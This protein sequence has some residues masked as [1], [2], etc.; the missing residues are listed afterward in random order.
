VPRRR[1]RVKCVGHLVTVEEAVD[2]GACDGRTLY[3]NGVGT[4]D[5][6]RLYNADLLEISRD[7]QLG[8]EETL[9]FSPTGAGRT[10]A[11]QQNI[12]QGITFGVPG[13]LDTRSRAESGLCLQVRAPTEAS[14]SRTRVLRPTT[15]TTSS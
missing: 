12:L 8:A 10:L 3:V 1:A 4:R 6:V 14:C 9:G 15:G 7:V 13:E 5:Q 11:A 2:I